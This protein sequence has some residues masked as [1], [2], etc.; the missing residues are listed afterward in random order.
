MSR[1]DAVLKVVNLTGIFVVKIA[2]TVHDAYTDK[3]G[4]KYPQSK[5]GVQK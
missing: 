2:G 1:A 3:H 5:T 4:E